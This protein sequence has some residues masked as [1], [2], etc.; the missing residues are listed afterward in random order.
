MP[1]AIV[2]SRQHLAPWAPTH[3]KEIRKLMA[4]LAFGEK[5]G[6]GMYRV[7]STKLA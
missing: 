2:Y 3:I 4:L 7:S 6:V 5:T 1:A